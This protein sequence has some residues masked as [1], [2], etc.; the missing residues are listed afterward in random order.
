MAGAGVAC[1]TAVVLGG[2]GGS[3]GVAVRGEEWGFVVSKGVRDVREGWA[4]DS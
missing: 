2:W 3:E 4:V 1:V